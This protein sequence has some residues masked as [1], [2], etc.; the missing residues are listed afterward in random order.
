MVTY[1]TRPGEAVYEPFAGSGTC[2]V[3]C[4]V[5]GRRC[6]ALEQAPAFC[7]V[8]VRRWEDLTGKQGERIP[9][10]GAEDAA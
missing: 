6:F 2:L 3:A 9:A 10:E 8:I 1:H 7:D 5:T 4:E